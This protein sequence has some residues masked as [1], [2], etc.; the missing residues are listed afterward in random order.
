MLLLAGDKTLAVQ[1]CAEGLRTYGGN[2]IALTLKKAFDESPETGVY[3]TEGELFQPSTV[4]GQLVSFLICTVRLNVGIFPH[5]LLETAQLDSLLST[6][7]ILEH[8]I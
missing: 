7:A 6:K 2:V 3:A 8:R 1:V 5:T 4:N